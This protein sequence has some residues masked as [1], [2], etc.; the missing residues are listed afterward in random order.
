MRIAIN[1]GVALTGD[2]GSPKRREF[3]VLGDVVNTASRMEDQVAGPG[4]IVISAAT[5]EH[6]KGRINVRPLGPYQLR[7]RQAPLDVFAVE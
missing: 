7:G 6:V 3:T 4:E 5:Y 2:I 1:S